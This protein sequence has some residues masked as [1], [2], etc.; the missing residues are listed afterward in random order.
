MIRKA[1]WLALAVLLFAGPSF[2][3]RAS[4]ADVSFG[5]SYLR[6]IGTGGGNLN[7][8]S[9]SAAGY[10]NNWFGIA[11]DVGVYRGGGGTAYTFLV[12]PRV[13]AGRS[14][15]M[16]PF[17]QALFGGMKVGVTGFAYSVGG[18]VDLRLMPHVALRPQ[19][20][21][22]GMRLGGG[23]GNTVRLS[24]SLVFRF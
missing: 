24:A 4:R 14:S 15:S 9:V 21:Y 17:V 16:S 19:V 23:T 11:G 13:S 12:G 22:I 5:Y 20:D 8:G 7:G 3:Q 10:L 18:G 6:L 2:A 1:I